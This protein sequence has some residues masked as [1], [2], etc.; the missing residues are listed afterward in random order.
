MNW[1]ERRAHRERIL[2]TQATEVWN[3]LCEAVQDACE[4]YNSHYNPA[5]AQLRVTCKFQ[6][7]HRLLITNPAVELDGK[8]A[9]TLLVFDPVEPA[10][11]NIRSLPSGS[12]M[13][14]ISSDGESA[15]TVDGTSRLSA[16]QVSQRVLE[17]IL[18]SPGEHRHPVFAEEA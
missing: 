18:F 4:S 9:S 7:A 17:P 11:T 6:N 16:D 3:D 5:P 14:R 8:P 12:Y 10:I 1:V 13:Y 15:F 2:D